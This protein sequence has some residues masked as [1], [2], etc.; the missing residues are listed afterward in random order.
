MGRAYVLPFF[1]STQSTP[2]SNAVSINTTLLYHQKKSHS[3]VSIC[4]IT[5]KVTHIWN[6]NF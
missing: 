1:V 3:K 2:Y 5:I 4:E 6:K